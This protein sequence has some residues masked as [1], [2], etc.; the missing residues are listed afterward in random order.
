[1][2]NPNEMVGDVYLIPMKM[3]KSG[4]RDFTTH[5]PH[6]HG[7]PS[8]AKRITKPLET[9]IEYFKRISEPKFQDLKIR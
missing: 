2:Q 4:K 1:M 8:T 9:N 6:Q 3:P 5:M 7:K